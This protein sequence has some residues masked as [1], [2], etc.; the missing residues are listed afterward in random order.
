MKRKRKLIGILIPLIIMVFALGIRFLAQDACVE[1]TGLF[2][3]NFNTIDHKDGANSSVAQ[4]PSGPITLNKL[5]GNFDI[6]TPSPMGARIYVAGAGDFDGDGM[7]E[8]IG[9]DIDNNYRLI[10]VE[11]HYE[12]KTNDGEDDDG[13]IFFI[14]ETHV[15]EDGLN[16]GP[17]A[18]AVADFNGDNY[19][20]FFFMK[21]DVDDCGSDDC[22]VHQGFLAVMY[23]NDGNRFNPQ[24]T[25]HFDA[26]NLDF[27]SL[28]MSEGIYINWAADHL[29]AVDIDND[30]DP[31]LLIISQDKIYL[32]RN[33]G[34]RTP[35]INDFELTELNYNE[36]TGFTTGRGGS[37]VA[38]ADFDLDGDIDIVAGTVMDIPY[39][40]YYENDGTGYFMR[41]ELPIPVPEATGTVALS[42][43]SFKN[44]G[45]IDIFGATDAWNAGNDAH[46]WLY[47]NQG[48][49]DGAL[50]LR[51][52]CLNDCQPIL[53]DPHDVDISEVVD[54]DMDGDMDVILADANHSGD[55]YLVIN[56][57]ADVYSLFGE[58]VSTDITGGLDPTR[59]AVTKARITVLRQDV[60]GG[61]STGLN[62]DYYFSNNGQ[63]WEFYTRFSGNAIANLTQPLEWHTFSHYGSELRWKA[64]LTAE[65]DPMAEFTGASFESPAIS[66]IRFEYM[67]VERR[68]YSRTSVAANLTDVGGIDRKLIIAGSF[69]FPGWQGHLR[70]YDV[71]DLDAAASSYSNLRTITSADPAQ[72]EGRDLDPD[73]SI[74]WDA[75]ELLDGRSPA[76][77]DIYTAVPSGGSLSRM[78][79]SST[80]VATLGPILA[81]VNNDNAGLIEF[82]RGEGRYWKL[83]DL[84]HSNPVV[85][86]PPQ[87]VPHLMGGG[88]DTF[89]DTWE[90]RRKVLY[91]GANDG[92]L[93]CFDLE[94]GEEVWAFIPYN[95]LPKLRNMWAVDNVNLVRYFN[96]DVYV[97]GTPVVKDVYYAGSWHT[98][99]ICGQGAGK[100]S[101]MAGG[102]N[103]YFALDVTDPDDPQ[104]LWEF[105]DV[106]VGESW[107]IPVIGKV[108]RT[109]YAQGSWLAFMGS[110]YDNDPV[111]TQGQQFYVV[112]VETGGAIWTLDAGEVNTGAGNIPNAIPGSPNL[113]DREP[114]DGY[115]DSV[116]VGDLDG[117]LWKVDTS[118]QYLDATTWDGTILYEDPDNYP[119]I[120]KPAVWVNPG[121]TNAPPRIYFGTGGDDRAPN[122]VTYSFIAM[123]DDA[124][125][126]VEWFM[127]DESDLG[128]PVE[129]Q[130]GELG[131]GEKVWADPVVADYIVYFSTLTGSIESVNPCESLV[132]FGKLYA[133]FVQSVGNTPVGGTAFTSS[134]GP[135]ENLQLVSKARS[136]VTI[137]E[138]TMGSKKKREVYIQEFNSSIQRLEQPVGSAL[139]I[140]TWREVYRIIKYP[141]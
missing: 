115:T 87:E 51:F 79:F 88:Y 45:Y 129:K 21:N 55:Y 138:R 114:P 44:D 121:V 8:L 76:S 96:R 36:P 81:D 17:A 126:E 39:L 26:P 109:G 140:K 102:L 2:T 110:G 69:F 10:L 97:D 11:N 105:T 78:E 29:S 86:G 131:I 48:M 103:Y 99:L 112:D 70:A 12:D 13:L 94:T 9:L 118:L 71:T 92:M 35:D 91:T 61:D 136:A 93:H 20:D 25:S 30:G 80:N 127:G 50:D 98:I 4:W 89:M 54:Y 90:D 101:Q 41:H 5:G 34:D 33:P 22:F 23:I 108:E 18:M 27:T 72:P 19:L 43:A 73:V 67:Y 57:L 128:L 133:R 123:I 1:N 24:F 113:T 63:D 83:G 58:G 141:R 52:I 65:E 134:T 32:L 3:E 77:R 68:E 139:V 135:L 82:V 16:C 37:S 85:V 74:L 107:S 66:E 95:L 28:F 53:P 6:G 111:E 15:Y 117:R 124:V 60:L 75:G 46:M 137:G 38:A 31:D 62:I 7:P 84:N 100:G 106:T 104:P 130:S 59:Y 122:N 119:I 132:G 120:T 64:V 14:D 116:Y 49:V 125:P 47:K 40:V 42:A 56:Q